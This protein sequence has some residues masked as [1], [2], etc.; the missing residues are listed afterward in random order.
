MKQLI[1]YSLW[2]F[3]SAAL[4]KSGLDILLD[5]RIGYL[6]VVILTI[7]AHVTITFPI[8]VAINILAVK[9]ENR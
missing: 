1:T 6:P 4:L 8:M 9:N 5:T 2:T 7:F 3:I